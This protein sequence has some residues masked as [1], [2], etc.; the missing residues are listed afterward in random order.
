M[1]Y[2]RVTHLGRHISLT[3]TMLRLFSRR[4]QPFFVVLGGK[5]RDRIRLQLNLQTK[6]AM[7]GRKVK[8]L[9]YNSYWIE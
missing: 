5:G 3:Q 9:G 7:F 2:D 8:Y 4:R 1:P 6:A